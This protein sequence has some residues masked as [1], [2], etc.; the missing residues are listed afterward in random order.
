LTPSQ[1]SS[2]GAE[3]CY[4]VWKVVCERWKQFGRRTA[5]ALINASPCGQKSKIESYVF[6][7]MYIQ[8]G[9]FVLCVHILE[10][11]FY[12]YKSNATNNL[13]VYILAHLY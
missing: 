7:H 3:R 12:I 1:H 9:T 4:R 13:L 2:R 8:Y 10:Y 11:V 6:R 5:G